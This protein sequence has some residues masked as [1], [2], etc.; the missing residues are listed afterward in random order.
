MMSNIV[1]YAGDFF[2]V[3]IILRWFAS[4]KMSKFCHSTYLFTFL[5]FTGANSSRA[6]HTKAM[7]ET[8]LAFSYTFPE[9]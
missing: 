5:S 2:T 1:H 3:N 6:R 4:T 9:Y 7:R 8:E